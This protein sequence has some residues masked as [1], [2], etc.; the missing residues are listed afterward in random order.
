VI[1]AIVSHPHTASV[2]WYWDVAIAVLG[3]IVAA[4]ALIGLSAI[5]PQRRRRG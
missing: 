5:F 2:P 1:S 3:V 4:A